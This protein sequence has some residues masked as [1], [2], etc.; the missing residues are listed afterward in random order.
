MYKAFR[1][2]KTIGWS[3]IMLILFLLPAEEFSRAPSIPYVSQFF[4]IVLFAGFTLFLVW[5]R[6]RIKF[7]VK[8]SLNVYLMA[9]GLSILFGSIVELLQ[10][11]SGAGRNAEFLD[12]LFDL[13]GSLL[14]TGIIALFFCLRRSTN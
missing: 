14:S 7:L 5:D 2:W 12:V 1:Y 10:V 9:I 8:P 13:T 6:L 11:I 3:V 4:H